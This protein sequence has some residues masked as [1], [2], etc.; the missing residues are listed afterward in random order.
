MKG[1][2][3]RKYILY[4][5]V[6]VFILSSKTAVAYELTAR[7]FGMGGA[8]SAMADDVETVLYN[9]AG[10]ADSG[11]IGLNGSLGFAITGFNELKELRM[12]EDNISNDYVND[13]L[14]DISGDVSLR[15]QL[16][17]G[18][19]ISSMALSYNLEDRLSVSY[20]NS[21]FQNERIS[22]G[23]ITY[24]NSLLDPPFDLGSFA[25]GINLKLIRISRTSYDAEE[26]REKRAKGGGYGVD[27][28]VLIKATDNLKVAVVV[29]NILSSDLS[30][31]G[32]EREYWYEGNA[33]KSILINPAYVENYNL[34]SKVRIGTVFKVP[35]L[36]LKLALDIDNFL[37][38]ETG[39]IYHFGFEKDTFFDGF[40]F[41]GGKIIGDKT[42]V[43]TLGF[44][45]NFTGFNL[46]LAIGNNNHSDNVIVLV[47]TGIDF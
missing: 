5:F 29:E 40:T 16:F 9:P 36:D 18:G 12:V 30:I 26:N 37:S 3:L 8:F 46:D 22:E 41:R 47:S 44:G 43:T 27:L 1:F 10:I 31:E 14:Q 13:V 7:S 21:H 20:D 38:E 25:Y 6:F 4:L 23:I 19:S 42:D 2:H 28:G 33:W 24:G 17:I 39:Q 34:E 11:T 35:V 45:I 15:S 32:E